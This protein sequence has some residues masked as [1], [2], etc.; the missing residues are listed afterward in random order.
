MATVFQDIVAMVKKHPS[1][2]HM[3]ELVMYYKKT[4]SRDLEIELGFESNA[5][6]PASLDKD[7]VI[8]GKMLFHKDY[9]CNDRI[10]ETV[11]VTSAPGSAQ[12][13]ARQLVSKN[14]G[15]RKKKLKNLV[16]MLKEFP[17]GIPMKDL[18]T[19]YKEVHNKELKWNK[20]GF[21]SIPA[22]VATLN[23]DLVVTGQWVIHK[24]HQ[25]QDAYVAKKSTAET[26]KQV[27]VSTLSVGSTLA[28]Q[29]DE[30][31]LYERITEVVE[32]Y[33]LTKPLMELLELCYFHHFDDKLPAQLYSSMYKNLESS[34]LKNLP[35]PLGKQVAAAK[36]N[37][38]SNAVFRASFDAQVR[39]VHRDNIHA[40]D[41]V[42]NNKAGQFRE[43]RALYPEKVNSLM[44]DV[45]RDL[46]KRGEFV[47]KE[48][49][50][51]RTCILL[52]L[53]SKQLE[54]QMPAHTIQALTDLQYLMRE[55]SMYI[56]ST[57]ALAAVCT[58]YE[59]GQSLASLKNKKHYEELNL[60]PLCKMPLI[61]RMF[62]IDSN[63]KDD[64]IP[65]IETV[66]ILKQLRDYRRKSNAPR[67]DLAEFMK[68]LSDHYKCDSPY[69]LGIK[70]T[71]LGLPLGTLNKVNRHEHDLMN[72]AKETIQ[73]ELEEEIREHLKKIKKNIREAAQG[74]NSAFSE[75]L[76]LRKKYTSLTAAQVVLAVY[77][78]AEKLFQGN[79]QKAVQRFLM[80]I[81]GNKLATSLF[82]MAICGGSL[83]K[84][85]NLVSKNNTPQTSAEV[86]TVEDRPTMSKTSEAKVKQYLKE[87]LSSMNS[88]SHL[89]DIANVEQKLTKHF[90]VKEFH[91]LGQGSFL[92]FLTKHIQLL[93]DEFGTT[94]LL[95]SC[96]MKA[97]RS[98]FRPTKQ[99][100]FEF[101]KQ[102]GQSLSGVQ[103][104]LSLIELALR[105]HYGVQDIRDLGF[106]SL[107]SLAR[108]TQ[109]QKDLA[110]GGPNHVFYESTLFANHGISCSAK[111]GCEEVGPLGELSMVQA[112]ASLQSCP[113]LENLSEWSQWDLIFKPRHGSLKDFINTNAADAGLAALEVAPGFLLRITTSTGDKHF[114]NAAMSLDPV[115]TAGHL[116]SIVVVDG[117]TNAPTAL[118][119]NHIKTSLAEAV[120]K[121]DLSHAEE[122]IS[123]YSTVAI[124][125]L[126]CLARIPNR[127]CQ[128]LLK[129][130]FLEPWSDVLGQTK[131]KVVLITMAKSNPRHMN[132]LH[133][134]GI[135]M[136]ITEWVKDYQKKY[137]ASN[138]QNAASYTEP[139]VGLKFQ[140][141]PNVVDFKSSSLLGQRISEEDE[142]YDDNTTGD[143]TSH[144][145]QT[146][147]QDHLAHER[148]GPVEDQSSKEQFFPSLTDKEMLHNSNEIRGVCDNK[149]EPLDLNEGEM[150][151]CQHQH[152]I[153][154]HRTIIEEIRKNEF[155]IGVELTTECQNL[156][157]NNQ[158]R[159]GRSLDRLSTELYSKETHFVLE[160]I[161]NADD[162]SYPSD[163]VPS[164]DF[165]IERD[166]ITILNNETG[167]EEANIRAICD[168]GRS[169]K[170]KHKYGYIGQKGIGF[171]SVF[172]VTDRPEIHSNGFHLFFDKN[173]GPM[174]YIL[175]HWK[176]DERQNLLLNDQFLHS[177]CTTKL[178]LPLRSE[179]RQ[180][181][182]L[183]HDVH[184]SL[185]LFLHRLR[186]ITIQNQAENRHVTMKRKDLAHNVIEVEHSDGTERWLVIK[187][188][189][190]PKKL[191]E[192]VDS[193]ELAL[194]FQLSCVN[195]ESDIAGQPQKQPVFAYLPLRSFGFRFIVQGDFEIP[196][197]REDVD[198]DSP[199]NQWLRAEIP[200]L[201]LQA[202]N[203]FIDHPEFTGL[204]G[205]CQILQ[206]IP[207]P[208]E[209]LDFF[210]PVASQIIQLLKGMAFLPTLNSDGQVVSKLPSQVAVCK[211]AVIRK[212]I[213]QDEL[214]KHLLLSYLHPNLS[215]A[216]SASLLAH[217]GV[218]NLRGTDVTMVTTAMAKEL[219]KEKTIHTDAGLRQLARLLVC[220]FR[221][222]EN[223]YG[224]ESLVL[225]T[226]RS[227]PIFPLANGSVVPLDGD[228]VFFPLDK[229]NVKENKEDQKGH[230]HI[231]Y[232]DLNVVHPSLLSCVEPLE[233]Q[234]VWE[235]L[236]RLGV[237]Q[238][239]PQE[240]L[241]QHIYPILQNGKWKSKP[242]AMV[243]SYLVFIK[244]NCTT[245]QEYADIEVPVLTNKG[246]K[247]PGQ[248]WVHFSEEYANMNL[249][250]MLPGY[251]WV[252]LSPNYLEADND[253]AGWKKLFSRLGVC[254][255]LIIRKE[256]RTLTRTELNSSP[257]S[258]ECATWY[259]MP[260][261][262]C[263][264]DDYPCEEF[265]ALATAQLDP[266]YL[267]SQRKALLN[268]LANNWNTGHRYSQYLNAQ[269]IDRD[270]RTIRTTKSSFY[271]FL[272][273]LKWMPCFRPQENEKEEI[274]Y[275]CP[276]TVYLN[277]P[278][279][280]KLLGT[281]VYYT[282]LEPS[283]F[284]QDLGIRRKVSVEVLIS[285]LK[286]W[287]V[288]SAADEKESLDNMLEGANFTS[289]IQHIH[290]VY[291]YLHKNCPQSSLK[292]L[293][294]H[295]PVVFIPL[296]QC[297]SNWCSGRFYHLR[298]VC[299][300]EPTHMFQRY[301][302][303]L[304]G[305][306]S[307]LQEPKVLA[308]FYSK[309]EDMR[310]FFIR[311]LGVDTSPNMN[312]YVALLELIASSSPIPNA[313]VLQDVSVLYAMLADKCRIHVST[314][315]EEMSEPIFDDNYC[316]TLK[317]VVLDK[318]VF[319]TK[320]NTWVSLER[321]P[322]IADSKELEKI[323]KTCKKICL[324]N[325]PPA[326]KKPAP[327]KNTSF[328]GGKVPGE[329]SR[330]TFHENDRMKFMNICGIRLLSQCVK[331]EP[332][333]ENWMPCPSMQA[334][335]RSLI[336]HVQ[337]F[338][339]H[340]EELANVYTQL[341]E[342]NIGEK[343]K[344]L[345]FAQVG[346]LYIH[347]LL[348]LDDT[349]TVM[350]MT[351]VICL[352][353]DKELCIQ[354][355]HLSS[356]LDICRELVKLFCTDSRDRKEL[357]NFLSVL[358][359]SVNDEAALERFLIKEDIR[360]LPISEEQWEVPEPP[361]FVDLETVLSM[362]PTSPSCPR[363]PS[364][365][366]TQDGES[367]L[368]SW[369][370]KSSI[371]NRGSQKTAKTYADEAAVEA[372]LKLWPPP[373][374]PKNTDPL[375]EV[376][377]KER[378]HD[379]LQNHN[380]RNTERDELVVKNT[381][382]RPADQ[383]GTSRAAGHP[384]SSTARSTTQPPEPCQ[385][386]EI[387]TSGQ[388]E[389]GERK[390]EE[391]LTDP[392]QSAT[393]PPVAVIKPASKQPSSDSIA[394]PE[395]RV[396]PSMFKGSER[397][398]DIQRPQLNLDFHQWNELH[399]PRTSLKELVLP[400]QR[401]SLVVISDDK[402]RD[403]IAI[404]QW[405]ESLVNLFLCHWRDGTE[406]DRPTQVI[407]CNQTGESGHPYDFELRF[408][409]TGDESESV[410]E[411]IVYVEVKS[412]TKKDKSFIVLSAN[413]LHFALE[414]KERYNIYRVY[415]AGDAENVRLCRIKNLAQHLHTKKLELFLFV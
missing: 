270:G 50:V 378:G 116:V 49:V 239:G 289:T 137:T 55:I 366:R 199:W 326:E 3:K 147:Q 4:Y 186:S 271:H 265:H 180:T 84:P 39:E 363:E 117:I 319:P 136:G 190:Q 198:R 174:G 299:W 17:Q 185:L 123:C 109:H 78:N 27:P 397:A 415:N 318:K 410:K 330:T 105:S 176:D 2:I 231:L 377:T 166:C 367:T 169:T 360:E 329:P 248:D 177:G 353:T 25:P 53:T 41:A 365:P 245:S 300:G 71:S 152:A 246:L 293:F 313:D 364:H 282:P 398:A 303:L 284:S 114:S 400:C 203:V 379:V 362:Y 322:M 67:V 157:K 204:G 354:K 151:A 74:T 206:F 255:G 16:T 333:T 251:D 35:D 233:R 346:K 224:D 160:L 86:G 280:T 40:L 24:V 332:L 127:I 140:T 130:V 401:P 380:G 327:K 208:D 92:G 187:K 358:I 288:K 275:L 44:E 286:Q 207:L 29:L 283:E 351:D 43:K 252:L 312:Q 65:Q 172:K 359:T 276:N 171:K 94:F 158:E 247:C 168:V 336:P 399:S 272:C 334:L 15:K 236:K 128:A 134:L 225:Q 243:V 215:P 311:L 350:E 395:A 133:R 226:L 131:S 376:V 404:G 175:P 292:E 375:Q 202:M 45:I 102:C 253:M 268:L 118:L 403:N 361:N 355:D 115:A 33:D 321:K 11:P 146:P 383:Q 165:V 201:F 183:F 241:T 381:N 196:S 95:R 335:V 121:E 22:M 232:K 106:G 220:N 372:N 28:D 296:E 26:P 6:L 227:L 320:E 191:S 62:K 317:G 184:P 307:S 193:T 122:D 393:A 216:P 197:S 138:S 316:A 385:P 390:R 342:D 254:D 238:V 58:L 87:T 21:S 9:K 217:L 256:R 195:S 159:L 370:P 200:Q 101:I 240:L 126:D 391:H 60:G 325:L 369:P 167:F 258:A 386:S 331:T 12:D 384:K 163:V 139:V 287:C 38:T 88:S 260:G 194:A 155:G 42:A 328:S 242:E 234:Q 237:H 209:V 32:K 274:Q 212:V 129:Q 170:G 294:L 98:F 192:N 63:T 257:W 103:D 64:D 112:L 221:A 81:S 388:K 68:H 373:A 36:M 141:Q 337:K 119:A 301:K 182:N 352:L 82:Q 120:A 59:L 18:P 96:G 77:K 302:L 213:N 267:L 297:R 188:P 154:F 70:I 66:D 407:W 5:A 76:G 290:N 309:L 304:H 409:P 406:P 341:I 7:L 173:C 310:D 143:H 57:E 72:E 338:L 223:G 323:F 273:S 262:D 211:D 411:K 79:M 339:Y 261:V 107:Q 306:E 149:S 156:F 356:K 69:E 414:K 371:G 349:N 387:S 150:S 235:L 291:N 61:H 210:K 124:F 13:A 181:Q 178:R 148:E 402:S 357:M 89:A 279:I 125:L 281:H 97:T 298:E 244:Q 142:S 48:K 405:G 37:K 263:V 308:P 305:P 382:S 394:V 46:A 277:E 108:L 189:L 14:G 269:V 100:M 31:H 54:R 52:Q 214:E 153:D 20:L 85:Q 340:H 162:N 218:R 295:N 164:L 389:R 19:V 132:C 315:H 51:S 90:K 345:N 75:D 104:D 219:M 161:Q 111:S 80:D 110:G 343:I 278:E 113:L 249:P 396:Q 34:C 314:E 8:V 285:Y 374:A 264:L 230:F 228:V 144:L 205:L 83:D 30:K 10:V 259:Q 347:Y 73:K 56:Q 250:K 412:T 1:G 266:P 344:H 229:S 93:E 222:V 99:E 145:N 91:S 413:E 135:L 368:I 324:L 179:S 392:E 408:D 23:N 47:T 348:E